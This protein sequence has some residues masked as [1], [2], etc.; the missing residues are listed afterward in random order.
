MSK[1]DYMEICDHLYDS[2]TI[3]KGFI[4]YSNM[5][6]GVDTSLL[7]LQEI[8]RMEERLNALVDLITIED[9]DT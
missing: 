8:N 9:N 5:K 6:K 2:I 3:L 4:Q 1:D 7:L